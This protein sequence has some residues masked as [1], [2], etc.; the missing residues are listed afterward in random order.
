[1]Q[2]ELGMS[3]CACVYIDFTVKLELKKQQ[4]KL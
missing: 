2:Y 1:M 4:Q 3:V